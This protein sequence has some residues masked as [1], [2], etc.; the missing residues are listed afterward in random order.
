LLNHFV[1]ALALSLGVVG[2]KHKPK[3]VTPIVG[4]TG[5]VGGGEKPFGAET[6][7]TPLPADPNVKPVDTP[8]GV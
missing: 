3:D 8:G 7:G 5:Q 1:I 6:H 2:C 4:R